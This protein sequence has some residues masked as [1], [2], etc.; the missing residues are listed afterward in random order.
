M[1]EKVLALAIFFLF[2]VIALAIARRRG[3]FRVP[4]GEQPTAP[5]W[6]FFFGVF[7]FLAAVVLASN[8][9]IGHVVAAVVLIIYAHFATKG[10][11]WGKGPF[12]K[13]VLVG[14]LAWFIAYPLATTV[15]NA[16]ELIVQTPHLEQVAVR[17]MRSLLGRP[18]LF[19]LT[20]ATAVF[21]VPV[22]EEILFRGLLQGWLARVMRPVWAIVLSSLLFAAAHYAPSQGLYNVVIIAQLFALGLI[23]GHL[24]RR[25]RSLFAS[26]SLH[27]LFNAVSLMALWMIDLYSESV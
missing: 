16:A 8:P 26:I 20:A 14:A 4:K 24:Y 7:L 11:V 13:A 10:A 12:G 5:F 23:L 18:L 25:Q 6:A 15:G 2:T 21:F 3:F 19:W 9:L 1:N 17:E 22:A 27:A